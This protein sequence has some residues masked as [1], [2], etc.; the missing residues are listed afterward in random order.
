[1]S[2]FRE[3]DMVLG[4]NVLT[5]RAMEIGS[6]AAALSGLNL[7]YV[8]LRGFEVIGGLKPLAAT[9]AMLNK[10]AECEEDD[11]VMEGWRTMDSAPKDGTHI[12]AVLTRE[13]IHDMD[14]V[15]R[16]AFSEIREI[17][18]RPYVQF[19]MQLPWHAGDPFD[20]YD[21]MGNEHMGEAVP[22]RWMPIPR[23][24]L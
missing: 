1:M 22:T 21:G 15:W 7:Q 14:D 12:L 6:T 13:G 18:Y 19:G 5:P 4:P 17:W 10:L 2:R 8:L 9:N 24:W 11:L 3:A 16:P 23:G 20:G